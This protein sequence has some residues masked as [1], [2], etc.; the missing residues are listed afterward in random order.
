MKISATKNSAAENCILYVAYPLLPVSDESCGGAEQILWTLDRELARRGQC[1]A[2]AACEGSQVC[3]ELL[4]TG[5]ET[6]CIDSLDPRE[7]QHAERIIKLCA[8]RRFALIHDHSGHFWRHANRVNVPVFATLHLPRTFYKREMFDSIAPNVYFNCV[9]KTQLRDFSDLPRM[10]GVVENGIDVERFPISVKKQEYLLWLGR[11]CPEKAPHLAIEVAK[12]SGLPLVMAGKVYPFSY[13]QRY[14]ENEVRPQLE[15][16]D[17]NIDFVESPSFRAKVELLRYA[18]ALLVTSLA[19]ETSSLVSLEAQACG[20]PVIAFRNGALSEVVQN[21]ETGYLVS[22][23][24]DMVAAIKDLEC[25]WP[26]SCRSFVLS[27]HSAGTMAD[28][29]QMLYSQI[30]RYEQASVPPAA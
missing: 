26:E 20:T 8:E 19:P 10:M 14:F 22:T 28:R 23:M 30:S 1:V 6:T 29:Y 12:K 24:D 17:A 21:R 2:V 4:S 3:G 25:I 13:H 18:K 15:L 7:V 5:T 27:H 11:V 16:G 9:S